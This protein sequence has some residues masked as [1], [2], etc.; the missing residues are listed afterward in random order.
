MPLILA[1][2]PDKRQA[3]Q[4]VALAHNPLDADIVVADS[5]E[6]GLSEIGSRVPDVILT[7]ALLSPKDETVL[8]AWLR[9]LDAAAAHVQTLT[10]PVLAAATRRPRAQSGETVFKRLRGRTKRVAPDGCDP[11]LFAE[12]IAEYLERAEAEREA[13]AA[14]ARRP[15]PPESVAADG[16]PATGIA[17]ESAA[18]FG[19]EEWLAP[20]PGLSVLLPPEAV[21]EQAPF[22]PVV[23]AP[24]I[25]VPSIVLP[26]VVEPAFDAPV[27]GQAVISVIAQEPAW[28]MPA[29]I[30]QPAPSG[31]DDEV[32]E[33]AATD[34]PTVS[35]D[36]SV[37]HEE[38]ALVHDD[39][40]L[41][42]EDLTVAPD[43]P[44]RDEGGPW[45]V[46]IPVEEDP[47]STER[48]AAAREA[49]ADEEPVPT[50]VL[51]DTTESQPFELVT[52]EPEVVEAIVD[53]QIEAAQ[54]PEPPIVIDVEMTP[55]PA[56]EEDLT[57][58]LAP[59]GDSAFAIE[60]SET[61][62]DAALGEFTA[63]VGA[64]VESIALGPKPSIEMVA[65]PVMEPPALEEALPA[66]E[67]AAV[68]AAD[69]AVAWA[70]AEPEA[71][72]GVEPAEAA[73][74]EPEAP[75]SIESEWAESVEP[76]ATV[77]VEPEASA[78]DE[79]APASTV[80][81]TPAVEAAPPASVEPVPAVSVEPPAPASPE[82]V[83]AASVEPPAPAASPEPVLAA[84]PE[85]VPV[86][87]AA[88][89]ISTDIQQSASQ[90]AQFMDALEQLRAEIE[91]LRTERVQPVV[92]TIP[93]PA[94]PVAA[95]PPTPVAAAPT[96][97]PE[98]EPAE[99]PQQD[100]AAPAPVSRTSP[101]RAASEPAEAR[102][103]DPEPVAAAGKKK[104]KKKKA[105]KPVQDEWG[106]FDPEQCGFAALLEKLDEVTETDDP[107]PRP[108]RRTH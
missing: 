96:S 78:N 27:D 101:K 76:L 52:A 11:R 54:E 8:A 84:N 88:V 46:T 21:V 31:F 64:K 23:A 47:W 100:E 17:S 20:E 102:P 93:A 24:D 14:A 86:V 42:R 38:L 6:R 13:Y 53:E 22:E 43:E 57:A 19:V 5:A 107:E 61:D 32:A 82:P 77:S 37:V 15:H 29:A 73:G 71:P 35:E 9:R 94:V 68:E 39:L 40:A 105:K 12:Q 51:P 108:A 72:E 7:S 28:E 56:V 63:P 79:L 49:P 10:I 44:H 1:I 92:I 30:V 34:L 98:P 104:A 103:R 85:P 66:P 55:S 97:T 74:I 50:A 67:P 65:A 4:L 58:A 45:E 41:V 89:P 3:S 87:E 75:A 36:R 91:R 83:L 48:V 62:L 16:P 99:E 18:S 95:A 33:V 80:E 26:A 25:V 2:E 70:S 90:A 59:E 106:F 81:A 69:S 60:L